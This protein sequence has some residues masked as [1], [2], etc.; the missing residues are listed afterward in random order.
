[1][2]QDRKRHKFTRN[3]RIALWQQYVSPDLYI[4]ANCLCCGTEPITF[5]NHEIGHIEAFS[6]G[7]SDSFDN[8]R[9]ICANCN[10]KMGNKNMIEYQ[11]MYFPYA[12]PI[13]N[14]DNIYIT[15]EHVEN[16]SPVIQQTQ[17]E[18]NRKKCIRNTCFFIIAVV[19]IIIVILVVLA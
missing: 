17:S 19:T 6:K 12:P 8:L 18:D 16:V 15:M 13:Y 4:L 5:N 1:M 11:R 2:E 10:R 14:S 7:G 9:P 3:E